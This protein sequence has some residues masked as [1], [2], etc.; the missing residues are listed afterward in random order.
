VS[1]CLNENAL[2]DVLEAGPSSVS[3]AHLAECERCRQVIAI[4]AARADTNLARQS[5]PEPDAP[6]G[7]PR[8]ARLP[9][10]GDVVGR[11]IIG[12]RLG[13][14]GM[15]VVYAARDPELNRD[16]AIKVIRPELGAAER[17]E[18][19]LIRESRAMARLVH[20]NV[21]AVYDVGRAQDH[22]FI[23]MELARDGTLADW[24]AAERHTWREIA[25][26]LCLAG[27][28]LI[29]AHEVGLVHRDFK[30]ENVLCTADG[31]VRV[32]DF[33]LVA[34][35]ADEV[36]RVARP[37]A[38]DS[39]SSSPSLDL[40]AP[41][42]TRTGLLLGTPR[43]MAPEQHDGKKAG[44]AADQFAFA[45]T[46]WEALYQEYPFAGESY[47]ELAAEVKGGRLRPQPAGSDVPPAV[48]QVLVRALSVDPEARWPS[49]AALV[50]VLERHIASRSA[51]PEPSDA[52][53]RAEVR[54]LRR[55][56][57][58]AEASGQAGRYAEALETAR[59]VV[60]ESEPVGHVPLHAEALYC[61]GNVEEWSGDNAAAERTLTRAVVEAARAR[62]DALAARIWC[63]L[64]RVIG[65]RA[66][67][68]ADALLMLPAAEAA[69]ARCA[70]DPVLQGLFH[71]THGAILDEHGELDGSLAATFLALDVWSRHFG[72]TDLQTARAFNNVGRTLTRL[73]RFEEAHAH[74]R[75]V[76]DI[77]ETTLG[78]DH[79]HMAMWANNIGELLF[80]EGAHQEA[81]AHHERALAIR[82]RSLRPDH[83]WIGL[84]HHNLAAALADLGHLDDARHHAE[85]AVAIETAA[86]GADHPELGE[87][88]ALLGSILERTGDLDGAALHRA[89]A[90]EVLA[91]TLRPGHSRWH[92]LRRFLGDP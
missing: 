92:H 82:Q 89:R 67:R 62:D 75:H 27:R 47:S 87:S 79:P 52:K 45:V 72:P 10:P 39:A 57:A 26:R 85:R 66:R 80:L 24:L 77:Y 68:T 61:L 88:L 55:R 84:S 73:G 31:G 8:A 49:M 51:L 19:R 12:H 2:T 78:P 44:P 3:E 30:P 91:R 53:V 70:D 69:L 17:M 90:R 76:F 81:R 16:L 86:L 6:S 60:A 14:G 22:V 43:Y 50:E 54:A 23:A 58:S 63:D 40:T 5:A 1:G 9:R 33:G 83:P 29:A 59:A 65:L 36:V 18:Q 46:L 74:Y 34:T 37:P 7:P 11:Y 28:G 42:L 38:A 41:L 35:E 13:A 25:A 15:S 64:L 21:L 56:L 4:L 71:L 20:P 32:A 48:H